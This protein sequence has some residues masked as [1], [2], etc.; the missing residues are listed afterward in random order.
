MARGISVHCFDIA[1]GVV[2]DGLRIAVYACEPARHLI[3][4]GCAGSNALLSHAALDARFAPGAYEI[5]FHVADYYRMAE[6]SLPAVPYLDVVRFRFNIDDGDTHYHF[7][8]KVTPWGYS[9][10][11]TTSR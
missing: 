5:A 3:Y 2:A 8:L 10:F 6:I 1:R 4:E 7:P 9:L 11:V